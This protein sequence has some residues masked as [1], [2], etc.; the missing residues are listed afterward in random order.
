[1]P[2]DVYRW[3]EGGGLS[4][5]PSRRRGPGISLTMEQ[6]ITVQCARRRLATK[7]AARSVS[8]CMSSGAADTTPSCSGKVRLIRVCVMLP[9]FLADYRTGWSGEC[10]PCKHSE[11]QH[12]ER[13]RII[14]KLLHQ[15]KDFQVA[16]AP[17]SPKVISSRDENPSTSSPVSKKDRKIA[18]KAAK[19]AE[20]PKVVTTADV[21]IVGSVLHPCATHGDATE[22]EE[23]HLLDDPDIM[24]NLYYHK[25][26]SN[27][28]E[29]P[30]ES[31]SPPTV[32][33]NGTTVSALVGT[34][35]PVMIRAA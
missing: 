27:T 10:A 17:Q 29:V 7:D 26:T 32:A 6:Y 15:L 30:R 11:D 5:L 16:Q 35:A 34:G 4:K 1:M 21:E 28:R 24:L 14:A 20:M 19:I 25:G 3:E 9:I 23:K 8:A 18:K 2:N 31:A 22:E 33:S 13:H 12:D